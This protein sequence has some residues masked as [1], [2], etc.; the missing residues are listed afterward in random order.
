MIAG[1]V[2]KGPGS[3]LRLAVTDRPAG[4]HTRLILSWA[5]YLTAP[6]VPDTSETDLDITW[7]PPAAAG[8]LSLRNRLG[9][10]TGLT[11]PSRLGVFLYERLMFALR[12]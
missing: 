5:R 9:I 12:F 6:H 10:L 7:W 1:L 2:E 11:P 4:T 3:A 8:R